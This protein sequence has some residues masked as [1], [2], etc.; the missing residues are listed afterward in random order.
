MGLRRLEEGHALIGTLASRRWSILAIVAV[1][2]LAP[3][4]GGCVGQTVVDQPTSQGTYNIT[5]TMDPARLNPPQ[6]NATLNYVLTDA[7]TNKPVISLDTIYGAMMHNIMISRDLAFFQH[8]YTG[9]SQQARFSM[10][11]HF[12]E[13][14]QYYSYTLYKPTGSSTQIL[15][16][17]V[18][19][20]QAG[21]DPQ[22]T[23]DADRVKSS[24]GS[25]FQLVLGTNPIKAGAPAQLVVFVTER[26]NPVTALWPYLDAPGYL[27]TV[28]QNGDHF[29]VETGAS[30]ARQLLGTPGAQLTPGPT[31]GPDLA[32]PL[33][34]VTAQPVPTF[35]PV[36]QTPMVSI[37][38]T[39]GAVIPGIGYGPTVAFTHTFPTPGL[40]KIWVELQYRDQVS[41]IPW[42]INVAP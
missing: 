9:A 33:A 8:S 30:E 35:L 15:T 22:L 4:L 25:Q 5:F 16:G 26:G 6:L 38:E 18:L 36:Q 27:W 42:V 14:S 23:P 29:A 40:Y 10:Y 3:V 1:G 28:D 37:V 39:P 2:V 34:T 21:P 13:Q 17:T 31:F 41:D 20:G 7:K 11:T 24:Y 12:P 19:A 32:G